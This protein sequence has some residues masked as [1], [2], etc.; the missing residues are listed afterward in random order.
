MEKYSCVIWKYNTQNM[1]SLTILTIDFFAS[2]L[3]YHVS[4]LHP[5]NLHY[6]PY[7]INQPCS[8]LQMPVLVTKGLKSLGE[9]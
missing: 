2:L 5:L 3:F 1:L 7:L 9:N 4:H 8:C 6:L